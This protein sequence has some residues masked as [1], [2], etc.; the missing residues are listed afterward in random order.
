[1]WS[2][3]DLKTR[4]K[5]NLNK[6][7]WKAVLV[8]FILGLI[9][10]GGSTGVNAR[11]SN[12]RSR[13]EEEGS[14]FYYTYL[15]NIPIFTIIVFLCIAMIVFLI[16]V[17]V[18]F[19]LF[20]PIAVGCKRFFMISRVQETE[21]NELG[22]AFTN[23]YWNVVKT[24]FLRA[25]FTSLWSML[26][27]I[28]GII[29]SYEYRMIPY[30]LAENPR[31]EYSEAF[32]ISKELMDGQKWDTFVL[33]LSFLGWALLAACTCGILSVFYVAPYIAYTD[34]ELYIVL[35]YHRY[36]RINNIGGYGV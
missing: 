5:Q 7:Y 32:R 4:A 31:L 19:F 16:A 3:V 23:G 18:R 22:F 11:V 30:L 13:L 21:L 12:M 1:M 20:A 15:R 6:C 34:V 8:A 10:G 25:L 27:V 29:K 2:R 17:A 9:S 28:P 14:Y 35:Q 33:D 24:E 26:F 36:N